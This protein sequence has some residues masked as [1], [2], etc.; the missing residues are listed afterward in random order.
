MVL[1]GLTS[2]P[3]DRRGARTKAEPIARAGLRKEEG[4]V[5]RCPLDHQ[6]AV[7]ARLGRSARA[8]SPD[9]ILLLPTS[10]GHRRLPIRT[11]TER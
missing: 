6:H 5:R 3:V 9:R 8:R 2:I 10:Y 1:A 11:Y 4:D 7:A